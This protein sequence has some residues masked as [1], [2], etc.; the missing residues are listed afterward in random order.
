MTRFIRGVEAHDNARVAVRSGLSRRAVNQI[1][2]EAIRDLEHDALYFLLR[3]A[4]VWKA[5]RRGSVAA[6][7]SRRA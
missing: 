2:T 7:V 4:G 1:E 6:L 5:G 3:S